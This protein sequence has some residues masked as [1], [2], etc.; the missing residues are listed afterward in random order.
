MTNTEVAAQTKFEVETIGADQK[1]FYRIHKNNTSVDKQGE[2]IILP[3]AFTPQPAPNSVEM[4]VNW[5]KYASA[6]STRQLAFKNPE[7][8]GVVSF[9]SCTIRTSPI[10]LKVLHDP[11]KNQAHSLICDVSTKDNPEIRM[12]LRDSCTWEI[13]P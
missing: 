12:K 9:I 8:N 2:I 13:K 6:E 10:S 7:N 3:V 4:S 11:T 1:L 5:E